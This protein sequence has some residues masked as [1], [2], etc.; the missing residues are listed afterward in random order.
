MQAD[1]SPIWHIYYS[2][3]TFNLNVKL[4]GGC[5][6]FCNFRL[7]V[8]NLIMDFLL[9]YAKDSYHVLGTT[10]PQLDLSNNM[11]HVL[12]PSDTK[13]GTTVYRLRASD[14]DDDYPLIFRVAGNTLAP[15]SLD[16]E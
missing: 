4:T 9:N 12:I 10:K 1:F 6:G 11:R 7:C 14:A 13:P 8:C 2:T 16:C 5:G 3:A 15:I